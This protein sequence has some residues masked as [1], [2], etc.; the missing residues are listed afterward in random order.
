CAPNPS[1]PVKVMALVEQGPGALQPTQVEL[2]LVRD[3]VALAGPLGTFLGNARLTLDASDPQWQQATSDE[4]RAAA[5]TRQ[6]GNPVHAHYI[7]KGGV[8]YPGDF[9]TWSLVTAWHGLEEA[10]RYWQGVGVPG[11]EM[12]GLQLH[13]F[14]E[15]RITAGSPVQPE[16]DNAFFFAPLQAFVVLPFE[17][18]QGVPLALNAGVLAHEFSHRVFNR[19]VY[20]GATLPAPLVTWP[21]GGASA[22]A[23]LLK[24][25]DEGFADFHAWSVTCLGPSGCNPRFLDP[26]LPAAVAEARDFSRADRCLSS[27]QRFAMEG[28]PLGTF[29]GRGGPYEV[30]TVIASALFQAAE[31]T[32]QRQEI[33]RAVLAAYANTAPQKP[34]LK[35][36]I[37]SVANQGNLLKLETLANALLAQVEDLETRKQLCNELWGRLKLNGRVDNCPVAS[38]PVSDCKEVP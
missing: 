20:G 10:Y 30:G 16:R 22:G 7:D 27:A 24:A 21:V 32:A 37:A 35:E 1:P 18:L 2:E 15:F 33:Q 28:E 11:E 17:S 8:L 13:Y 23:N 31:K 9:H 26:S 29:D 34:G 14:P 36:T 12:N 4:A 38:A 6:E 3:V 25:A 19:R 5:I